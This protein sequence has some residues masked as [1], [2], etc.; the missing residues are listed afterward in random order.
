MEMVR[1]VNPAHRLSTGSGS[2][3]RRTDLEPSPS[4]SAGRMVSQTEV[5]VSPTLEVE[6]TGGVDLEAVMGSGYRR[7]VCPK[8]ESS[9][10]EEMEILNGEARDYT[11]LTAEYEREC[12]EPRDNGALALT[13]RLYHV[14]SHGDLRRHLIMKRP[15]HETK[16]AGSNRG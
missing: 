14:N 11:E 6:A 13:R 15:S 7:E 12:R 3:S 9:R 4:Q 5:L 10:G 1:K 2:S 16:G 8:R